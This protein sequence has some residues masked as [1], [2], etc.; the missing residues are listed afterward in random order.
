M[1]FYMRAVYFPPLSRFLFLQLSIYLS[2]YYCFLPSFLSP[3]LSFSLTLLFV[4]SFFPPVS[5]SFIVSHFP[6]YIFLDICLTVIL[7]NVFLLASRNGNPCLVEPI[8]PG[9]FLQVL[10]MISTG[11]VQFN[12]V[13]FVRLST[14]S[15]L[16]ANPEMT[17]RQCTEYIY[18]SNIHLCYNVR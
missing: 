14:K 15:L 17:E 9:V 1:T 11:S 10:T 5:F 7:L 18:N 12:L 16:G 6:L 4:L 3:S 13:V 2:L 8:R